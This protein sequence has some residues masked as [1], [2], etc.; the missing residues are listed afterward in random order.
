MKLAARAGGLPA[1]STRQALRTVKKC[2]SRR[3]PG[4]R[5]LKMR[6]QAKPELTSIAPFNKLPTS[7]FYKTHNP[8]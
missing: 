3:A 1:G 6:S 2:I 5:G 8:L 4:L 7:A